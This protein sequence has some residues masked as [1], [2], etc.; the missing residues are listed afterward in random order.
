MLRK[1]NRSSGVCIRAMAAR[2]FWAAVSRRL[3]AAS[4]FDD[5]GRLLIWSQTTGPTVRSAF[6]Q[7]RFVPL[8]TGGE[9]V[10]KHGKHERPIDVVE[11]QAKLLEVADE[12]FLARPS[13][14]PCRG[15]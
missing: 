4:G 6:S 9:V 11:R 10:A 2:V 8:A 12:T 5:Q 3:T 1:T 15:A 14:R 13:D 7:N